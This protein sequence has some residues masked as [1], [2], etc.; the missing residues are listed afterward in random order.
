MFEAS[1]NLLALKYEK[2]TTKSKFIVVI[3]F[4]QSV[5]SCQVH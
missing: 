4:L 1:K 2:K 5:T 3:K